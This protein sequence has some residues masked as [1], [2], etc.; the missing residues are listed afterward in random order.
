[1]STV[2]LVRHGRTAANA[3]GTLAGWTPGVDLDDTGR[4][5]AHALG[6]RLLPV[7]LAAVDL[8]LR[9]DPRT[10]QDA[11][12]GPLRTLAADL[13][14]AQRPMIRLWDQK[15]R[16]TQADL[17]AAAES[18]DDT[19]DWLR[20]VRKRISTEYLVPVADLNS[21]GAEPCA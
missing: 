6:A 20:L 10:A 7:P 4:A 18:T 3:V 5:Q 9:Q 2:I 8:A 13:Q 17:S 16:Q 11:V 15:Y 19:H 21:A 12:L 14:A 1:V